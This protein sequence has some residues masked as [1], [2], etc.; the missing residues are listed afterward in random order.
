MRA[1]TGLLFLG[2]GVAIAQAVPPE[3]QISQSVAGAQQTNAAASPVAFTPDGG[4]VV[5]WIAEEGDGDGL[6]IVGRRFDGSGAPLAD[7]FVVNVDTEGDQ[8]GPAVGTD[9]NGNFTVVWFGPDG[10]GAGVFG[11]QFASDG[12]P[13]VEQFA[14]NEQTAGFQGWP[15]IAMATDGEFTVAWH[16]ENNDG[17]GFG[18]AARRFDPA[19]VPISAEQVVNSFRTGNQVFPRAAIDA[20]KEVVVAWLTSEQDGDGLGI[21][22]RLFDA[23]GVPQ[24][25][26]FVVNVSTAGDQ[27]EADVAKAPGGDFVVVWTGSDGVD[28]GVLGRRF[29]AQA[30]AGDEFIVNT[31]TALDQRLPA[32]GVSSRG[33]FLVAWQSQGQDG[34]SEGVYAK[35]FIADGSEQ[36]AEFAVNVYTAGSQVFPAASVGP[37]GEWVVVWDSNGQ[38]GDDMGVFGR[39]PPLFADGFESGTTSAWAST[40]P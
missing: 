7:E 13:A 16:S 30:Q 15:D 10:D 17:D 14:V 29:T 23:G 21:A 33:D 5:V 32:V 8:S 40:V 1:A 12:T 31:E 4:F 28:R 25:P 20:D 37:S 3:F 39:L 38:D 22:A 9:G 35:A 19:G 11:R 24:A 18:L 36:T 26:D 27:L 6:G 2:A 34:S